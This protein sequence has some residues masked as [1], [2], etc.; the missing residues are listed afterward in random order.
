V[1]LRVIDFGEVSPLRSQTLWHAIA[2]GVS[3]G[4]PPTLSF[5]QPDSPYV[6]IGYHRRFAEVD[7]VACE[8]RGLPIFR[9]MVGGGPVYLDPEQDFFQ[10]TIPTGLA[11]GPHRTTMRTLLEP[12]VDAFRACGVDAA[13]DDDGELVVG[14]RKICG[15]AGGQ[16]R[17]AVIVVGNLIR[18]FDHDAAAA[19]LQVPDADVRPEIAR[20][21]RRYVA[22]TPC[23]PDAYRAGAVSAYAAALGLPAE[24]GGLSSMEKRV[25]EELDTQFTDPAWV[26]GRGE[27]PA[28]PWRVKIK[29]GVRMFSS[30][31][32]DH[33][34][35]L[36]LAGTKV[37]RAIVSG[38]T[39]NGSA[40]AVAACLEGLEVGEVARALTEYGP[41]AGPLVPLAEG[42]EQAG[43]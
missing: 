6:S 8:T 32:G 31:T 23:D 12:A 16:I 7:S 37:L 20:L 38:T 27:P 14:D 41:D 13:L 36:S 35:T 29:S 15:H 43:G 9:R 33:R 10:I 26:R 21:M 42:A 5:M 25:L 3:D 11:R 17:D 28:D 39:L 34:L 19:S 18:S 2:R 30:A 24:P 22:P 1:K 40:A 4:G